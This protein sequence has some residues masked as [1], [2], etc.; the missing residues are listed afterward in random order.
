MLMRQRPSELARVDGTANG[1]YRAHGH[2]PVVAARWGAWLG[3][4]TARCRPLSADAR[5]TGA[6]DGVRAGTTPRYATLYHLTIAM[7]GSMLTPKL[8]ASQGVTDSS[9]VDEI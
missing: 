9:I 5:T 8:L 1:L 6:S 4:Q 7:G 2:P 3:H